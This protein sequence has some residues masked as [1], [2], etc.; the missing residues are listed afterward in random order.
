MERLMGMLLV[1]IAVQMYERGAAVPR[2]LT[3]AILVRKVLH[4]LAVPWG[5]TNL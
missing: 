2:V 3:P 1:I 5:R 4:H